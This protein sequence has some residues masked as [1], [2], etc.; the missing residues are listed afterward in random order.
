MPVSAAMCSVSSSSAGWGA[1]P[2]VGSSSTSSAGQ[3]IMARAIASILRSP[4][5]QVAALA[6]GQPPQLRVELHHL[7]HPRLDRRTW[8]GV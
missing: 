1:S 5:L 7:L 3:I 8:A 4:P 2:A 6:G